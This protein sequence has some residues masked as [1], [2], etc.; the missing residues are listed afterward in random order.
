MKE[1]QLSYGP[2]TLRVMGSAFDEAWDSI[3]HHFEGDV[4]EIEQARLRLA[5]AILTVVA[6][7]HK[8]AQAL[9]NEALQVMALNYR[10]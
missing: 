6:E 8:D 2:D 1:R 9:K 4:H 7:D 10:H 3:Q 5:H